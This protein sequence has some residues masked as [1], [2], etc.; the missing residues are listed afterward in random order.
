MFIYKWGVQSMC[1]AGLDLEYFMWTQIVINIKCG[2]NNVPDTAPTH[3]LHYHYVCNKWVMLS[4]LY[5]LAML[6][7]WIITRGMWMV[8]KKDIGYN[9]S[10]Q[11]LA[12]FTYP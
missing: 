6:G 9:D 10:Q 4:K 3:H 12:N 5:Y 11:V 1:L 7:Q 8:R 2:P